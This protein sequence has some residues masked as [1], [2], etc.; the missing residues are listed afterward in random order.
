[1]NT[2]KV[3]VYK[4]PYFISQKA[5]EEN[6]QNQKVIVNETQL[7][8]GLLCTIKQLIHD[9]DPVQMGLSNHLTYSAFN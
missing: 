8:V 2:A 6:Y 7:I 1:M 9:S 4:V 5:D 3:F